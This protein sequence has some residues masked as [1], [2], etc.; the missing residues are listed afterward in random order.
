MRTAYILIALFSCLGSCKKSRNYLKEISPVDSFLLKNYNDISETLNTF[1]ATDSTLITFNFRSNDLATYRLQNR[2]FER[3]NIFHLPIA[4]KIQSFNKLENNSYILISDKN[5]HYILDSNKILH[6]IF[7]KDTKRHLGT[8][9]L[10]CG[11]QYHPLIQIKNTLICTYYYQTLAQYSQYYLEPSLAEYTLNND[12]LHFQRSYFEK[13]K[14]LINYRLPFAKYCWD[15]RENIYLLYPP[16]DT[17]YVLNIDSK[18]NN[19]VA[20]NN[21]DYTKPK[22]YDIKEMLDNKNRS[23]EHSYMLNNFVYHSIYFNP[24]TSHLVIFY[25]TPYDAKDGQQTLKALVLDKTFTVKGYFNFGSIPFFD[26]ENFFLVPNKGIAMPIYD[27][28]NNIK[29]ENIK[30]YIYNF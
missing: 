3:A 7:I 1:Y 26:T 5:K 22:A 4:E 17:L 8:N 29:H 10:N 28:N 21:L 23:Q 27:N 13:P 11:L 24:I 30:Y 9:F 14:A 25:S 20:I 6:P 16:Y 15:G 2:N 19:T 18:I 12:S